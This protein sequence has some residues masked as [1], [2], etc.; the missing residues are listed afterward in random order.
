MKEN[1]EVMKNASEEEK[2]FYSSF[3]NDLV[4]NTRACH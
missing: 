2:I 4:Q 3:M 1:V